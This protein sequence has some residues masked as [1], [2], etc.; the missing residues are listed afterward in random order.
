[1]LRYPTRPNGSHGDSNEEAPDGPQE[2]IPAETVRA[3]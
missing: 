1:V 3:E 2:K